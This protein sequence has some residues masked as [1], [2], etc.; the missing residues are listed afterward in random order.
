MCLGEPG[1]TQVAL[2]HAGQSRPALP[3]LPP[4]GERQLERT[5]LHRLGEGPVGGQYSVTRTDIAPRWIF[6]CHDPLVTAR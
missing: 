6:G 5:A 3:G 2:S 4:A 1:H